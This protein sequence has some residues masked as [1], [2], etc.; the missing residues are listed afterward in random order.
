MAYFFNSDVTTSISNLLSPTPL[1]AV[2]ARDRAI[3]NDD[4]EDGD[5]E[6]TYRQLWRSKLLLKYSIYRA[7]VLVTEMRR[8]Y[9]PLTEVGWLIFKRSGLRGWRRMGAMGGG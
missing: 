5:T 6:G 3:N 8:L 4:L 1:V 2:H 9:A 7:T